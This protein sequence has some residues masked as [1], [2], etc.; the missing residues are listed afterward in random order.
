MKNAALLRGERQG[1]AGTD[2]RGEGLLRAALAVLA[3]R[4]RGRS[5][6]Q[7]A[8]HSTAEMLRSTAQLSVSLMSFYQE[9]QLI[10]KKILSNEKM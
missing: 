5:L 10:D 2:A 9:I 4:S 8:L 7:P 6:H 1:Q 3:H